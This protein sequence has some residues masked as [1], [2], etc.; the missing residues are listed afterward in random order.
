M[1]GLTPYDIR[2]AMS[3]ATGPK[4]A[5]FVP[6][7]AFELLVRRQLG[8]IKEPAVQCV[9]L[10]FDELDR[11]I[12]SIELPELQRFSNLKEDLNEA[13]T[14]LIRL[15]RE[16]TKEMIQN[17][18]A[19]E[20]NF[21]NTNHPNFKVDTIISGVIAK[22]QQPQQMVEQPAPV[23]N[24]Y[25]Q[26]Q[27]PHRGTAP[28]AVPPK[29]N[30]QPAPKQPTRLTPQT[31]P[32]QAPLNDSPPKGD[33][34]SFFGMFFHS[35]KDGPGPQSNQPV[36]R[37]ATPGYHPV[38][39]SQQRRATQPMTA[40]VH[41]QTSHPS[42]LQQPPINLSA[43]STTGKE[44]EIQLLESLLEA[45]FNIVRTN[46][47]DA[48]PKSIMFFL[49]AKSKQQ[50]QNEL[51]QAL[52]KDQ[53]FDR[54]FEESSDIVTRRRTAKNMLDVLTKAQNIMNE[55]RDYKLPQDKQG[56]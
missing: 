31:Q 17:I 41:A 14:N 12:H 20:L 50:M 55:V 37:D 38:D 18:L 33:N 40:Q 4:S 19:M 16:P 42:K 1:E 51:V 28:P 25:E 56:L 35:K 47:I 13:A 36:Y 22:R 3:N 54:L 46:L 44:F 32:P 49:V 8:R 21:I 26:Q 6:E 52:Y 10:V 5:L 15:C 2:T 30:P 27:L 48:V 7:S 23:S 34:A 45:Y 24:P 53:N 9:D 39:V 11:I 29:N 43:P